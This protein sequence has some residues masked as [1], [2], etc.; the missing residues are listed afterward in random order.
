[1]STFL[2][3]WPILRLAASRTPVVAACVNMADRGL[4]D[5][6]ALAAALVHLEAIQR[7]TMAALLDAK[8]ME[9][10]PDVVI[11]GVVHRYIGPCPACG[12]SGPR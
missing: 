2:Q 10:P 4:D 5:A 8:L 3:R 9:P 12:R 11:D 7:D 1:V 6:E